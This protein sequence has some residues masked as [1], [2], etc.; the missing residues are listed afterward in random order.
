MID[1]LS[2]KEPFKIN[3]DVNVND[4]TQFNIEPQ[5]KKIL[6]NSKIGVKFSRK[7]RYLIFFIL[8]LTNLIM[9]MDHGTIPAATLEIKQDLKIDNDVLGVFGALVYLGN[10][11]GKFLQIK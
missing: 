3:D 1:K 7:I 9:N 6:I 2:L 8:V 10:L 5:S 4:I 11:I